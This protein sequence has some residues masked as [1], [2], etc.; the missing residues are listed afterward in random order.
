[1]DSEKM[2]SE[3]WIP[4]TGIPE[5]R[6]PKSDSEARD[7]KEM[8]SE[9]KQTQRKHLMFPSVVLGFWPDK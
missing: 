7:I 4:K 8:G 9:A 2:A 6:I 1:M 5:K 3:K